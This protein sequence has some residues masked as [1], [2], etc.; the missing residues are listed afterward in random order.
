MRVMESCLRCISLSLWGGGTEEGRKSKLSSRDASLIFH[1][2]L[3]PERGGDDRRDG[4]SW[5]WIGEGCFQ[6]CWRVW[7]SRVESK[8][9]LTVEDEADLFPD[10][11]RLHVGSQ[12]SST[13]SHR[14]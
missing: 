7:V 3:L 14:H 13:R 10:L 11:S 1:R 9:D 2:L 6:G 5:V 8:R 4:C 12:T